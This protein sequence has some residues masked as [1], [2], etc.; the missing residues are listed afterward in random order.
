MNYTIT[1]YY[2]KSLPGYRLIIFTHNNKEIM[3]A[4]R[5]EWNGCH[6][7]CENG[8]VFIPCDKL[9]ISESD[10][11]YHG[12]KGWKRKMN[13]DQANYLELKTYCDILV[14]LYQE[15]KDN[16]AA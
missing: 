5:R 10:Y 14:R 2:Y 12:K 16:I 6:F 7:L 3:F 8:E 9:Y 15:E 13:P 11:Y 4:V 1:N